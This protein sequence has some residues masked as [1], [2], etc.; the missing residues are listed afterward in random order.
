MALIVVLR[1][2]VILNTADRLD[3]PSAMTTSGLRRN[4]HLP[5]AFFSGP[6]GI[7]RAPLEIGDLGS[8]C[9]ACPRLAMD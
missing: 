3:P 7:R 5:V 9:A 2:V 8:P 6:S 4:R 1:V